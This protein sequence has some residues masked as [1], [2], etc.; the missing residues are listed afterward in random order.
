MLK[1]KIYLAL[2]GVIIA[3]ISIGLLKSAALGVDPFTTF[4]SGLNQLIPISYGLLYIIVNAI[5]LLFSFF[6]DRHYIGITTFLNLFLFGYIIQYTHM[7]FS[8]L[9]P[10][11]SLVFRFVFLVAALV[12]LSFGSA[13]YITADIG[14]STYDAFALVFTHK[15]KLGKFKYLR[16]L[17][18]LICVIAGVTLFLLGGGVLQK[19]T[20][21]AGIGTIIIAFFMGPLVDLFQNKVAIPLLHI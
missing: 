9:F 10:A 7:L 1:R 18:D 14:V 4:M 2:S 8:M 19:V 5:M 20:T 12:G 21:I 3:G 15:W 11:P 6:A 13:L 17:T 16:I